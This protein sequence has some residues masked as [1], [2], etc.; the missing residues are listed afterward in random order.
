[1]LK[2]AFPWVIV[3]IID[4]FSLSENTNEYITC[5][6]PEHTTIE[7]ELWITRQGLEWKKVREI[8]LLVSDWFTIARDLSRGI[9]RGKHGD[10]E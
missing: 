9:F 6:L 7:D 1:M 8:Q 5:T 2:Q 10:K 3:S 4:K